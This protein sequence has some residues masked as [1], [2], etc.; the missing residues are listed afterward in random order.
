MPKTTD[1]TYRRAWLGKT[2]A[3]LVLGLLAVPPCVRPAQAIDVSGGATDASLAFSLTFLGAGQTA[4]L[5]AANL[6]TT[7]VTVEFVFKVTDFAFGNQTEVT[8]IPAGGTACLDESTLAEVSFHILASIVLRSPTECSQATDYP[9][10]C[11]VLGSLEISDGSFI[12]TNRIHMEPV[13][14][15]GLPGNPRFSSTQQ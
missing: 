8:Q 1:T 5:C 7:T 3:I 6:N 2:A 14:L 12:A 4:S 11:R 9:G 13:L 10:K 15:P